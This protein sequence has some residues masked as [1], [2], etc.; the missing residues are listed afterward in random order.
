VKYLIVI[1]AEG[2]PGAYHYQPY[3]LAKSVEQ[4][5]D[6]MLEYMR[7][8]EDSGA[9]VPDYFALYQER[10]GEFGAPE[11]FDPASTELN[12]VDATQWLQQTGRI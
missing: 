4:A 3:R 8:P 12:V 10:D 5:K 7:A 1:E 9:L 11:Y 2:A 6:M